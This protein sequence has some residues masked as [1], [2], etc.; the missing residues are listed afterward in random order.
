MRSMRVL[1]GKQVVV[2]QKTL[3]KWSKSACSAA[4]SGHDTRLL[5]PEHW[6][7]LSHSD[8]SLII[9]LPNLYSLK[10]CN[11]GEPLSDM[12]V[13]QTRH[14]YWHKAEG[15]F[16]DKSIIIKGLSHSEVFFWA[17]K[18]KKKKY[19]FPSFAYVSSFKE[20]YIQKT[21]CG[22]KLVWP[23]GLHSFPSAEALALEENLHLDVLFTLIVDGVLTV[24]VMKWQKSLLGLKCYINEN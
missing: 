12:W 7:C 20:Y 5:L 24:K 10:S 1:P 23:H 17:R 22:Y 3:A 16:A 18:K 2:A 8:I 19:T 14:S 4:C 13:L 21:A 6:S 15:H 9:V 11:Y